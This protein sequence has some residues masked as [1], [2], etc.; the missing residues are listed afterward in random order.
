MKTVTVTQ[1]AGMAAAPELE[2]LLAQAQAYPASYDRERVMREA[3]RILDAALDESV[4]ALG[5]RR[6]VMCA[7]CQDDGCEHC[8]AVKAE[9]AA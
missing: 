5:P 7:V 2:E 4:Q 1:L 3:D 6:I 9:E 8:P